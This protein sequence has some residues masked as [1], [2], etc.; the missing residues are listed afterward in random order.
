MT[1]FSRS[2]AIFFFACCLPVGSGCT[3][4]APQLEAVMR[5]AKGVIAPNEVT[6]SDQPATW[7]ASVDGRG[8]VLNPYV[9]NDLVV[10]AS[11][12]G[13]AIAFDGWTIRSVVGF[14]LKEP[15]SISGRTGVRTF[16]M[17]GKKMQATCDEWN[18]AEMVWS[19]ICSNGA[20]EIELD[21]EGNIQKITMP[22]GNGSTI[23]TLRVAK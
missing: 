22:I 13:D 4:S 16:E 19:Q 10:F 12:D 23:V 6:S 2:L 14:G 17:A 7:I 20:G 1:E 3:F 15:L 21:D 11:A 9:S 18:L 8:A 5:F